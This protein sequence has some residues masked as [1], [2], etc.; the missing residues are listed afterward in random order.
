MRLGCPN[1][2]ALYEVADA[3]I[4]AAGREVACSA[5]EHR[6]YQQL[7]ARDVAPAGAAG[8]A[9]AA[10]PPQSAQPR[11]QPEQPRPQPEQPR[12]QPEHPRPRPTDPA[13]LQI[14][15]EEAEQEMA[16]RRAAQARAAEPAPAPAAP[17]EPAPPRRALLPEIDE[18]S[19]PLDPAGESRSS[20]VVIHSEPARRRG[21][22]FVTG[23][24]LVLAIAL[25]A[26]ATYLWAPEIAAAVPALAE[27]LESYVAAVDAARL[28]VG[29]AL[30]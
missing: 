2:G 21:D 13:V 30:R 7:S 12:P 27:P 29:E 20:A 18:A 16:R 22:G 4:P 5:C 1:C 24:L 23:F 26:V 25:A 8:E 19:L 17:A 6:W 28:G 11:P 14:L 9:P 3:A 10:T 15:R